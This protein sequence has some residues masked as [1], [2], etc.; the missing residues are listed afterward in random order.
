M[1]RFVEGLSQPP[2]KKKL[3][4]E[5]LPMKKNKHTFLPSSQKD[6]PWLFYARSYQVSVCIPN[7]FIRGQNVLCNLQNSLSNRKNDCPEQCV[8]AK[9]LFF[10]RQI[11][12]D[13]LVLSKSCEGNY[14]CCS[15]SGTREDSSLQNDFYLGRLKLELGKWAI[16]LTRPADDSEKNEYGSLDINCYLIYNNMYLGC[17]IFFYQL[18]D[19]NWL[20]CKATRLHRI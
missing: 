1:W 17:C 16:R 6:R 2:V 8:C 14:I 11:S 10:M 3:K 7:N 12:Q 5:P 19:I 18:Q 15:E 4:Q 13:S 20:E 9:L